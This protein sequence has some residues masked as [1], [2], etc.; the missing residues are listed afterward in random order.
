MTNFVT[1]VSYFSIPFEIRYWRQAAASP[2]F[3]PIAMMF[4]AFIFL[5]GLSHAAMIAIMPIGPWWAIYSIYAPM[6]LVSVATALA[7]RSERG[8]IVKLLGS[9]NV[10]MRSD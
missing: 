4:K 6:A 10:L 3:G 9:V 5:C 7:L 8:L 1:A 2:A